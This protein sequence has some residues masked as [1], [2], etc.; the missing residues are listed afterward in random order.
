MI[1]YS[2]HDTI[3]YLWGQLNILRVANLPGNGKA[4]LTSV[5]KEF[6]STRGSVF[7]FEP[8]MK[9]MEHIRFDPDVNL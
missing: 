2:Y 7:I 3:T 6:I 9:R 4:S 5:H 1:V 8:T